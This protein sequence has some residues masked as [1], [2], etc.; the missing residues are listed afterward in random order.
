MTA[1]PDAGGDWLTLRR[2]LLAALEAAGFAI[3]R[4]DYYTP[5]MRTPPEHPTVTASFVESTVQIQEH[6]QN[7]EESIS[8]AVIVQGHAPD[9]DAGDRLTAFTERLYRW[10]ASMEDKNG[11]PVPR[12]FGDWTLDGVVVEQLYN[13]AMVYNG[14]F[15]WLGVIKVYANRLT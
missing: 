15:R 3:Y 12:E 11:L 1:T 2:D 6:G 13:R 7:E 4:D 9:N 10:L 14:N 8:V 5:E